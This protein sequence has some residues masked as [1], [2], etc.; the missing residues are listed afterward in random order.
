MN[1][2]PNGSSPAADDPVDD[3][4]LRRVG[5]A[6]SALAVR[7]FRRMFFSS[8]GSSIGTW[9]QNVVLPIYVYDR[10]GSAT[11]VAVIIFAQLGPYLFFSLPAGAFVDAVDRRTWLVGTQGI[12]LSFSV[13]LAAFAAND[14]P[15]WAIF[16]AQL[17]VGIGNALDRPAWTAMLPSLVDARDLAGAASLN[18]M[19]LN[20]ARI[21]GPLIVAA[22]TPLGARPWH[23]FTA[24]ATT[25][26]FVIATLFTVTIPRI[27]AEKLSG[28]QRFISGIVI[29][30]SRPVIVRLMVSIVSFSIF[31]LSFIG[32]FPAVASLNF[33]I[34]GTSATYKWL[35]AVWAFGAALGGIG[36]GTFMSGHDVRRMIRWGFVLTSIGLTGFGV[37]RTAPPAFIA[38]FVVGFGYF[39]AT[40]AMTTV[41]QANLAP[42]ERG[43][44]LALWFMLFGGMVPVGNLVFGPLVDRF[45]ARWLMFVGA[46]WAL[47][48]ARWCNIRAVEKRQSQQRRTS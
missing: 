1:D 12:M 19:V 9:I 34:D 33:G 22:F 46:A 6:R 10:T 40:T 15:M 17:G 39:L 5:S 8:F 20:M 16:V 11:I 38:G 29:A 2:T 47:F 43:R 21:L 41:L 27:D 30:R 36:I 23:F 31:S 35:Y 18:G 32:L 28:W 13:L 44:V 14:A 42:N 37:A 48:L 7:D 45:G 24:N 4:R 26:L 25:Y 3:E